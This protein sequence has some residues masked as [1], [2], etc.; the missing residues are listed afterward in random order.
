M[1]RNNSFQVFKFIFWLTLKVNK[2]KLSLFEFMHAQPLDI[3]RRMPIVH[4]L[5]L[6]ELTMKPDNFFFNIFKKRVFMNL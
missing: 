4:I 2:G 5:F 1:F 6:I 3:W